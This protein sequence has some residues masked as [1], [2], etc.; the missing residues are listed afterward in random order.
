MDARTMWKENVSNSTNGA[1]R[2]VWLQTIAAPSTPEIF[3]SALSRY[4]SWRSA[5]PF[6]MSPMFNA[7]LCLPRKHASGRSH[8][9]PE[10]MTVILVRVQIPAFFGLENYLNTTA[11]A[12]YCPSSHCSCN[13]INIDSFS[14]TC[15][16]PIYSLPETHGS[17]PHPYVFTILKKYSL[18]DT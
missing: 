12:V 15:I 1:P 11:N 13:S 4:H 7:Q 18:S 5:H 17:C 10:R 9:R 14:H 8:Y 3:G 16:H 6:W 2:R